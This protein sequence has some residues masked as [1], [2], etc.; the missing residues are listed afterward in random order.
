MRGGSSCS[1][2]RGCRAPRGADAGFWRSC[3]W[4]SAIPDRG[5]WQTLDWAPPDIVAEPV[6]ADS[7]EREGSYLVLMKWYPAR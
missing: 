1:S 5:P 3:A 4:P 2:G 7:E 6:L